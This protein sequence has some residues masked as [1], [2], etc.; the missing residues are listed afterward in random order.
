ML[1]ATLL[2]FIFAVAILNSTQMGYSYHRDRYGIV[3]LKRMGKSNTNSAGIVKTRFRSV[4][5]K[6]L[7]YASNILET[8]VE[9]TTFHNSSSG[10]YNKHV[11][12]ITSPRHQKGGKDS[13]QEAPHSY[14]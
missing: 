8:I 12:T 1:F 6:K 9:T 10:N 14:Y 13:Y 11:D 3:S 2:L 4:R 7:E 5:V